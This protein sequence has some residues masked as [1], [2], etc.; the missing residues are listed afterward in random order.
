[1][2]KITSSKQLFGIVFFASALIQIFLSAYI[3]LTGDEAEF[4]WW[5]KFPSLTYHGR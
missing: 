4:F 5:G 1:M 3:P 2:K